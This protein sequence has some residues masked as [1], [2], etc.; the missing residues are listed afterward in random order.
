MRWRHRYLLVLLLPLLYL[1]WPVKDAL[2]L[3]AAIRAGDSATIDR[4]VRWGSLRDS[5]KDELTGELNRALRERG[6][7]KGKERTLSE[8]VARRFGPS[9]VDT[10]IERYVTPKGLPQLVVYRDRLKDLIESRREAK[11]DPG[12]ETQQKALPTTSVSWAFFTSPR[13]FEIS[14][15]NRKYPGRRMIAGFELD[16]FT[17]KLSDARIVSTED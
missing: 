15:A 16:G 9:V 5:L 1:A 8:A 13:R 3:R 10:L 14:F 12:E 4:L 6:E 2:A 7:R 11:E 17:W